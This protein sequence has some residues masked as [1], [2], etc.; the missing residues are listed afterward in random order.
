MRQR[1]ITFTFLLLVFSGRTLAQDNH[2]AYA[3][4]TPALTNLYVSTTG[5]DN[6]DGSS[7]EQALLTMDAAWSRIPT[8]EELTTGYHILIL[9]GTYTAEQA[10][11][12][13]ESHYGTAEHPII[14]EA[15]NGPN[16]A[17]LPSINMYDNRYVY[18]INLNLE[19]GTDAFH[20]EKCDHLLLRGNT[21]IGA[22]PDTYNGQETVK[23]N[24]SQYVF[25]ED[26]DISGAWDN[27]VDFVAVQH[28]HFLNN[29]IHNAG[30]WCMYLKGGSAYFYVA[31]N[32]YYDCGT[33]GFTAGQ[34]TGYQFMSAPYIQYEAYDIKFVNNFIHDTEGAGIG[35]QGGYNILMAY[36]TMV[37]VGSRSHVMEFGFGS[38]SC[39]GQGNEE[40]RERC[41]QYTAAG[42]W[43]NNAPAD[44]S[45]FVR[46]PNRN[47]FVYN[48]VVY[49]PTGY[50]SGYQQFFIAGVFTGAEQAGSNVPSPVKADDNLQIKSNLIWNGD[51]NMPLGIDDISGCQA[52]NPICNATQLTADN[53]INSADPT[54]STLL[55]AAIPDFT[56]DV[57]IPAG[58]VS[59]QIG[60]PISQEGLMAMLAVP[61]SVQQPIIALTDVP[62]VEAVETTPMPPVPTVAMM[63]ANPPITELPLAEGPITLVTLGDSLTEGAEDNAEL[64]G[65]PGR[66]I[67]M[68]QALRPNSTILNLGHSGWSSDALITG[69]QGLPSE[70]D[71]AEQAIKAAVA[72]GQPA[73][74]LVWIGSNDL[75]Y[76]YGYNNPD[77]AGEA[78]DLENYG[79]NLDTIVGRLSS[80]GARVMIAQLDD[81]SLRPVVTRGEAFPDIS[82]DEVAMMSEQVKR[83]NALIAEK[84]AGYGAVVVDFFNT[85]I[86]TDASMLADDG[87]HPNATGYDVV[88]G[89]WFETMKRILG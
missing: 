64:G 47:V 42:G 83:Y 53:A 43:G 10:P 44:G 7:S 71:Q 62:T 46:I 65:Y 25:I 20:C 35:V 78:A 75:F 50:Q 59:N 85:T 31:G 27:A 21:I 52:D 19:I 5:D 69:D 18:F 1:W 9:P 30:D 84:A 36:N 24:Q 29:K 77:A 51:A 72:Q 70:L 89:V 61:A 40:G 81:Q 68:V 17:Y 86:F 60:Q 55:N 41:D 39:D 63:P 11:N 16:T 79:R 15:A 14:I 13:W 28:G 6:H 56:W 4:G 49:N 82:K 80:A 67:G 45:N 74:A 57:P 12:Y 38:R 32:E 22:N 37:R 88:A 76:L 66:L 54:S 23:V 58:D 34:G 2:N 3:I 48:N 33:G 26:N 8:G 87:N 73:V